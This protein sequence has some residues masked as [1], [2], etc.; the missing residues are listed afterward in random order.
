MAY[1]EGRTDPESTTGQRRSPSLV[2]HWRM[3]SCSD[4]V[5]CMTSREKPECDTQA[6][7]S[8]LGKLNSHKSLDSYMFQKIHRPE[9]A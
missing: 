2:S 7:L 3:A 1:V 4:G 5:A 9:N 6:I 8:I